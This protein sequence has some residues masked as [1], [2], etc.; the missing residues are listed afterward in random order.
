[1]ARKETQYRTIRTIEGI[2]FHLYEDDKGV[3]KPH[4]TKGPAVEYPK[5]EAKPDEYFI[6]G[7]KYDYDRWLELSRP[8][9]RAMAA[10]KNDLVE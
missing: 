10:S 2:V 3:V 9:R 7:I 8:F 4:S 6:F 1:M 5:S